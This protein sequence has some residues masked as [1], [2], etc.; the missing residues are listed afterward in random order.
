MMMMPTTT[1]TTTTNSTTATTSI[2]NSQDTG[3][4]QVPTPEHF[5][6][7]I[8]GEIF[9]D[10]V[11]ASDGQTYE[12]ESIEKWI[13]TK[14]G[15]P[16]TSPLTGAILNNH[17]LTPNHT[18]KS[19]I[20]S[21]QQKNKNGKHLEKALKD[22]AGELITASSS[23]ELII[24]IKKIS[25]LV[26]S[27]DKVLVTINKLE[28]WT[29][30]V[31]DEL[32]TDEVVSSF[33]VLKSQVLVITNKKEIELK[34]LSDINKCQSLMMEKKKEESM[35]IDIEHKKVYDKYEKSKVA[36]EK[37]REKMNN[38]ELEL[39]RVKK[40]KDT[41][42][43]QIEMLADLIKDSIS[44]MNNNNN[45]VCDNSSSNNSNGKRNLSNI[46]GSSRKTKRRKTNSNN[47]NDDVDLSFGARKLFEDGLNHAVV[48]NSKLFIPLKYQTLM[49]ASAYGGFELAIGYC[50]LYGLGKFIKD[51]KKGYNIINK[52]IK[53]NK[54]DRL[55]QYLM[56]CMYYYGHC[57]TKDYK[58]A[59]AWYTKSA[60]QGY[61]GGQ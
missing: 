32:L 13:A 12:R 60:E 57:V 55:A 23:E 27:S 26:E 61:A 41:N 28:K 17:T 8:S 1:T 16:V 36:F 7:S 37:A 29:S 19:M 31:D 14:E 15:Q 45:I 22:L 5:I 4:M 20:S 52:Y 42:A 53:T 6:C 25:N 10:P 59:V 2:S 3:G 24:V 39:K 54:D 11:I 38:D 50:H 47:F 35:Q 44:K 34:Q 30:I 21:W 46:N 49:E 51:E 56:G 58:K 33:G 40:A 9:K 18:V 43:K 48:I